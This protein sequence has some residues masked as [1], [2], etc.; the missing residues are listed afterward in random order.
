MDPASEYPLRLFIRKLESIATL[1]DEARR[2]VEGL[3][4]TIRQFPAHHDIVVMGDRPSQCCLILSGWAYRYRL[5]DQGKRQILSFHMPG[6]IPDLMSL[7]LGAMDHSLSTLG[8]ATLAFIPH[9]SI[10]DMVL[11]HPAVAGILWRETLVDAATFRE[12]MV[13][14]GRRTAFERVAHLFCELYVRQQALS[15]ARDHRCSVPFTQTDLGDALGLTN[16]HVNRVLKDMR[17]QGLV[18]WRAGELILHKW[19]ELTEIAEFD[20]TYL[21]LSTNEAPSASMPT[22]PDDKGGPRR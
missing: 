8:P 1:N 4:L 21:H 14:I 3:P 18:T 19:Q 13:S 12:W 17:T 22:R 5:L 20:A 16:V 15:L 11:H 9:K 7:H 2:C 10:G 6:D